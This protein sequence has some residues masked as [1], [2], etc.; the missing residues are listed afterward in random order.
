MLS[1]RKIFSIFKYCCYFPLALPAV[2]VYILPLKQKKALKVDIEAFTPHIYLKKTTNHF[3]SFYKLFVDIRV[4]RNV[5]YYRAKP[6]SH[7]IKFLLK[8]ERTLR[9]YT[10]SLGGGIYIQHGTST[11]INARSVGKNFFVNQNVTIGWRDESGN[12]TIGD[13]VR[14]GTGAVVLGPITIGDNV[15]IA[16]G[17]VVVKNVPANCTVVPAKSYICKKDGERVC[18]PL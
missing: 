1:L 9:I 10:P 8:E 3:I 15:N 17:A 6:F 11:I 13:N 7:I 12:P 5:F 18:H 14:I 2:I 16:A 4:F